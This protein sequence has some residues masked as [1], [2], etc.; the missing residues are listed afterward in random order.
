MPPLAAP[1]AR[2]WIPAFA[3]M[4]EWGGGKNPL[5]MAGGFLYHYIYE[6]DGEKGDY[7]CFCAF[8]FVR[9]FAE[10]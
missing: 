2:Q 6:K 10:A 5:V 1:A 8:D 9:L 4:T 7:S 3:G